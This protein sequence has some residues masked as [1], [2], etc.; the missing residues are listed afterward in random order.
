MLKGKFHLWNKEQV[1]KVPKKPGVYGLYSK[2]RDLIYVGSSGNINKRLM[3][4]LRS[5]F[6][7]D[8][9][10][11]RYTAYFT[12]ELTPR[13]IQREG[14]ILREYVRKEAKLPVCNDLIP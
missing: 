6:M 3:H 13:F 9:P 1:K 12:V 4:Y 8:D 11:K 7:D 10:C 5:E 2:Q 14:S